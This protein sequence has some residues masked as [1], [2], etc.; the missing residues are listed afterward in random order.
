M[1]INLILSAK[2]IFFKQIKL[3]KGFL[4]DSCNFNTLFIKMLKHNID[5]PFPSYKPF[6][7][8]NDGDLVVRQQVKVQPSS[9]HYGKNV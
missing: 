6:W 5:A 1:L 7:H 8:K 2:K 4:M 3:L 9:G